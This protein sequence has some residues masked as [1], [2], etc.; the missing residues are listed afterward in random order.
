MDEAKASWSIG[1]DREAPEGDALCRQKVW[2]IRR[3]LST[4]EHLLD[5][6][7][8]EAE[9]VCLLT[10]STRESGVWL[11]ALPVGT[12][13]LRMDDSSV[14]VA[15]GLRLGTRVCG[16]HTCQHCSA[17]VNELGRHSLSCRSSEGRLQRHAA[18]NDIFKR[19]LSAAHIPSRLEPTG[20]LRTNGKWPDGVT[21]TPWR[22]GQLLVWDATC[23]D[24]SYRAYATSEP[25]CVAALAEDRKA[26][27]YKNLPRSH[28]FSPLSIETMGTMGPKTRGLIRDVGR[29]IAEETG[30]PRS[31]DFL[32]Q[33]LS[34]AV[35]RGNCA[36][37]LG[38]IMM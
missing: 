36:S 15:V 9:R 24:T 16:V 8:D 29:R 31:A 4:S 1:H 23:P 37:V 14:R 11:R 5:N 2:D 20:L 27:K 7:A 25:G 21:L 28:W 35:Q 6:A 34:V 33:R 26:D 3:T 19:A 22:C 17:E 10:V 38:G 32:L 18:L 30:E 12:P 13:G